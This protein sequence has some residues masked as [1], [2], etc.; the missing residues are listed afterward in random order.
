MFEDE[1]RQAFQILIDNNTITS[2]DMKTSKA[3]LDAIVTT[4]KLE[5]HFRAYR[6]DLISDV[7]QQPSEGIHALS[8]VHL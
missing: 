2:E 1:D 3:A 7:R 6:D 4:I 5:E 8:P